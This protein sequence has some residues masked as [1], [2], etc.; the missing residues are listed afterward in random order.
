[1]KLYRV[2]AMAVFAA[3]ALA[4][5]CGNGVGVDT[6]AKVGSQE[7]S[8]DQLAEV[9][10]TSQAPLET[11][12]ARS[13]AE[14]WVNYQLAGLAAARGDTLTS[15]AEMDGGLWSAIDNSR[16]KRLYEQVSTTWSTDTTVSAQQ[17]YER[18][19]MMAARHILVQV[20]PD[21]TP[22]AVEAARV[23]AEGIRAEATPA[24]FVRLAAR[25]D[26]P[27]A[28]DR[29]GDLGVFPRGAMV[30]DFETAVLA[31]EPGEISP[32][33]RTSFGFHVIYRKPYSEVSGE[34]AQM[35]DQR[36]MVEAESTY[37]ASMEQSSNVTLVDNAAGI[38]KD[39]ARNPLGFRE[40]NKTVAEYKGGKLTASRLSDWVSAY[41]P[42]AQLR[43]Q[44]IT[45]PDSIAERF[46]KTIV[47][48]ELLLMKADS[49]KIAIDTAELTNLRM[50]F[51]NNLTMAW[52]TMGIEPGSLS[53]S[54]STPTEREAL[55]GSRVS[56]YFGKLVK[57]EVQFAD[58][59]YPVSRALQNKYEFAF[60]D[61]GIERA[62]EKA[63]ALRASADSTDAP[64]PPV[65]LPMPDSAAMTPPPSN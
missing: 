27:G 11:E 49:A 39:I 28:G 3:A 56:A 38:A 4:A 6:A 57:N 47:R 48:N 40:D 29:G 32:V 34:V 26:E 30:P 37:L 22:E 55:A 17:R 42:Q 7:L 50:A 18:G 64:A 23:K 45:A 21:A 10:S 19:D 41:P 9:L 15:E 2:P 5:A 25:S 44:L 54:A 13:V 59:A 53:D 61:A 31:L 1:M 24:N 52:T 58:V 14:L 60:N 20:P 8:V 16:V 12:V 62:V 35:A 36:R 51:R 63:K 46:I 43:P 65:S 33:V